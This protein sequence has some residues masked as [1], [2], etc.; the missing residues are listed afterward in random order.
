M[1]RRKLEYFALLVGLVGGL[2]VIFEK[3]KG[4]ANKQS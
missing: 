4:Y 2:I 1:N 3:V